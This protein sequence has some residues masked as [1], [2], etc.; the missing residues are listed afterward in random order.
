VQDLANPNKKVI[1]QIAPAVRVAIGEEFG[2]RP[3]ENLTA[4]LVTAL[5][6][7]GF[8]AVFDTNFA[9]DLTIMEEAA[10]FKDRLE[11]H[12]AGDPNVKLPI[13]TSCCPAWVNFIEHNF[14]DMLD[15]PSSAKSPQQMFGAVVKNIWAKAEGYNRKEVVCVSIMPCLAKKYEAS[16]EEFSKDGNPDVDYSL[17]TRELARLLKQAN[18]DLGNQEKG[19]FDMPLGASTGAADIFGRTG[20]VIEAAT[21]TAYEWVTGEILENVDFVQL[22]GFECVRVAE[23]PVGDLK[24]RIGIAHGLGDAR[25]LL[26]KVRTGEEELHAIEIMAC[27]GG[28]V[29]G[30][31]QPYHHG[32]FEIVKERAMGLQEIDNSK[33]LRKSNDNPYILE[34]YREYLGQPLSHEAERLLHTSYY[35]K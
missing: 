6:K 11:K 5:R 7:L 19:E 15:V 12:L 4:E 31:G 26:E 27:K 14:P 1:V 32:N 9:A 33:T 13:L 20:G 18:I 3:G 24:L 22:R 30:G 29:G 10:E 25:K 2:Y 21:R 8:S 23:V 34:L 35:S 28:C 16:R 17:S